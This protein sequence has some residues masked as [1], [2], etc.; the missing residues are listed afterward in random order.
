MLPFV[1]ATVSPFIFIEKEK[2]N[3]SSDGSDDEDM[4]GLEIS[5]TGRKKKKE[6]SVSKQQKSLKKVYEW[7][8]SQLKVAKNTKSAFDMK[9][10]Q[11]KEL[12]KVLDGV[13]APKL[14]GSSR[15]QAL[16]SSSRDFNDP[17]ISSAV[18]FALS[19][20]Y[21]HMK[22]TKLDGKETMADPF[23][24]VLTHCICFSKDTS[25]ILLSLK[26][27]QVILRLD[28]PSVPKFRNSLAI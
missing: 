26:C 9:M 12:R 18:S 10:K 6:E 23:V 22:K 3:E 7:A 13:S 25:A 14:T 27:L 15:N 19:L 4:H 16:R 1:Y 11:K 24:K 21:T 20:L 5:T 17:A 2:N 28:L 8:P